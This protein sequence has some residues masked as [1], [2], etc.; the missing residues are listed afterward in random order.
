LYEIVGTDPVT[1][2]VLLRDLLE[3]GTPDVALTDINLSN[4]GAADPGDLLFTRLIQCDGLNLSGGLFFAFPASC[5]APLLQ[6]YEER[7]WTV[8]PKERAQ[9][10]FVFFYQQNRELGLEQSYAQCGLTCIPE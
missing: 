2:Q 9:R 4:C 3:P 8:E 7:M 5:R 10:M 6:A 1:C